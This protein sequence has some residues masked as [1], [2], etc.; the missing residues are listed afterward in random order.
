MSFLNK[1]M[2]WS[3]AEFIPFK[4]CIASIYIIVGSYF[5]DFFSNYYMPLFILFAVATGWTIYLWLRKMKSGK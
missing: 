2:S 1:K 4:L 5:H 3:N